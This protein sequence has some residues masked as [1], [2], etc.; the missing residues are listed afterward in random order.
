[1]TED[2]ENGDL[3]SVA[4]SQVFWRQLQFGTRNFI[5]F[6]KSFLIFGILILFMMTTN[7]FVIGNV[8]Q[9]RT[10]SSFR[11]LLSFFQT[12]WGVGDQNSAIFNSS[13]NPVDFDDFGGP[14]E[15]KGGLNHP[16]QYATACLVSVPMPMKV[17]DLKIEMNSK[18][19]F[20]DMKENQFNR[21]SILNITSSKWATRKLTSFGY[22]YSR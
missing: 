9:L 18:Y 1:M 16:F 11:I 3:G 19:S 6:S 7:L 12:S 15:F 10:D 13:H 2:R 4:P 8:K 5:S 14:S 21:R 17:S 20:T 22:T